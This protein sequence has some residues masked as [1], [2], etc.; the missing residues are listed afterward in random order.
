[1]RLA[2]TLPDYRAFQGITGRKKRH[3]SAYYG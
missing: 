1:M 2:V 3:F